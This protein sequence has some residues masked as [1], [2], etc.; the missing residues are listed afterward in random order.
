MAANNPEDILMEFQPQFLLI[1]LQPLFFAFIAWEL[2]TLR[3]RADA[4]PG[5]A[6]Y[7]VKDSLANFALAAFHEAGE[8]LSAGALMALYYTLFDFRLFE[9]SHG[10]GAFL[11]LF[12]LQDLLY[13]WFHRLSHR[14][15]WMWAAHVVHHSS[16]QLNFTTAFRQSFMYFVAGNG[17]FWLPLVALG[18]EPMTVISVV[19]AN[20]AYQFFLHTQVVPKLG[21][22]EL[23][24][25]TPSHHRVHHSR[26][27]EYID[28]NFAGTL[29]IW[30]K[31]FGTFVEER[32]D[33]PC[34]FG[35]TRQVHSHNPIELTFHEW[36]EMFS[37]A[38]NHPDGLREGVKHLWMPPEW[39]A[40]PQLEG[41]PIAVTT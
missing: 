14:I 3:R 4:F 26:N 18:F 6:Q 36:R 8:L 33:I 23:I 17:L 16:E 10:W 22:F 15:R 38:I 19:L 37:D 40:E 13:Y 1:Y 11:L 9:I 21:W 27:E 34:E 30:D 25:N 39:E 7:T 31:L 28:Q 41:A 20:L 32:D 29:I 35:I 12:I 5:S 2:Y 24:F